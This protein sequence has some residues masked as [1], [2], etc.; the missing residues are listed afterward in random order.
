MYIL[1]Q[2]ATNKSTICVVLFTLV[3]Y[4]GVEQTEGEE[5]LCIISA[6]REGIHE[7]IQEYLAG[8]HDPMVGGLC[9]GC[10]VGLR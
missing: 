3:V 7:G 8:D 1:S 5:A 9:G 2:V 10:L 6:D 4:H